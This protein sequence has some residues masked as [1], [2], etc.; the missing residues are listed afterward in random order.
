M[1][2]SAKGLLPDEE[3]NIGV[4]HMI[5]YFTGVWSRTLTLKIKRIAY[6]WFRV[7]EKTIAGLVVIGSVIT[8]TP[9][10]GSAEAIDIA[11]DFSQ[12]KLTK[13]QVMPVML[14]TQSMAIVKT[15]SN[16]QKRQRLLTDAMG[17]RNRETINR[18]SIDRIEFNE[19][20]L[21]V[22]RE[23]VKRAAEAAGI[24][25]YWQI[26]EAVWQVES[27]KRWQTTV[28]SY[29]GAQGPM[30]FMRGTWER[31]KID[32]NG[33]GVHDI[34]YAPDAVYSG[35]QLLANAGLIDDNVDRALLA[36]NHAHWYVK[37]VKKVAGAIVE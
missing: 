1:D 25:E 12:I 8:I 17:K 13:D 18:S 20:D 31:N 34:N 5:R 37:K 2:I 14:N 9:I 36:Y 11:T 33:D 22:K 15:E 23:L 3:K 24:S 30:Q 27:G 7:W 10:I 28:R 4:Y 21:T 26:V 32:G 6:Q 16:Y 19:P 29:A 35:A